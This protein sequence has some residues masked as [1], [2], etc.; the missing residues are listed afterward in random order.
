MPSRRAAAPC[1]LKSFR[2]CHSLE[3]DQATNPSW[4][5]R[6]S[7]RKSKRAQQISS[8]QAGF[9]S[10]L[11]QMLPQL[12]SGND[13]QGLRFG[14]SWSFA[15]PLPFL[16]QT[17]KRTRYIYGSGDK[18]SLGLWKALSSPIFA[19]RAL[20]LVQRDPQPV[21]AAR[22]EMQPGRVLRGSRSPRVPFLRRRNAGL[23]GSSSPP[24]GCAASQ[25][26]GKL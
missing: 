17:L 5:P 22:R 23:P 19:R 13:P 6:K 11:E 26:E 25:G 8:C 15:A 7:K 1:C 18:T 3:E 20:L 2:F 4:D 16:G 9:F 10:T 21:G 24:P 14:A 12:T